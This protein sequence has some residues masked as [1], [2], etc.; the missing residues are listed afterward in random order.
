[1]KNLTSMCP[2][3]I[4][5]VHI[6]IQFKVFRIIPT[7][8]LI[9]NLN[10]FRSTIHQAMGYILMTIFY[11]S[12]FPKQRIELIYKGIHFRQIH[13]AVCEKYHYLLNPQNVNFDWIKLR[14]PVMVCSCDDDL[15]LKISK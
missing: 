2:L 5:L 14:N 7:D 1:M 6:I 12:A 9:F 15:R 4:L 11:K 8:N 13:S 3:Q 10:Q